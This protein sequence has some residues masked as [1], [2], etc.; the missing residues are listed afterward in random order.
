MVEFSVRGRRLCRAFLQAAFLQAA[1]L[2]ETF[3]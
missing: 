1:F 2:Q 3:M